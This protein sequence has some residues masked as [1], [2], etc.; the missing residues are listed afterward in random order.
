MPT[1][2]ETIASFAHGLRLSEVPPDVRD[3]ARL[4]V[5]DALGCGLAAASL[6][7]GDYARAAVLERGG[8][9]P[10]SAIGVEHGLSAEDAAFVNGTYCHALDFDDTHS[11]AVTHVSVTVAPAALAVAEEV[12]ADGADVMAAIVAG[13]ETAVRLGLAAASEFHARGFH[14]TAICGVFGAAA[15][16][17]RVRGLDSPT[18]VNAL[19]IAGSM[20]SGILE[21]LA[22]GSETKRIHPGWAAQAAITATRLAAHGATGPSSV[23][24]GRFGL[25]ATFLGRA[26]IDVAGQFADLGARWETPRI[27]FK[28]FPACHYLHA[29]VDASRTA[30]GDGPPDPEDIRE[31]VAVA[32][33]AAVA[34]VLEPSEAKRR[35]RTEYEA[36]F[37]LPYSVAAMLVHGRV[38]VTSYTPDAIRDARVLE[39]A[40]RVRYETKDYATYPGS[41][42]GGVRIILRDGRELSHELDHQRGGPEHP[43]SGPEVVDKFRTNAALAIGDEAHHAL[44]R[45][46]LGLGEEGDFLPALSAVRRAGAATRQPA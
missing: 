12:G 45:A 30:V 46:V 42:P 23:F 8:G 19:G 21:Y 18:T 3:A 6:G 38:D 36:K 22:D 5:L 37:S 33:P 17:A 7:I 11:G 4:H 9:G 29:A 25:Y 31:I 44:E 32:P 43:M 41:F 2:A 20:A 27:A 16:A 40:A 39:L 14:P 28:P 35:P 34:M 10:A 26:D 13:N 15:A 1:T 24:E